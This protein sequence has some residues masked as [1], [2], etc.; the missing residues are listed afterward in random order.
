[1][2]LLASRRSQALCRRCQRLCHSCRDI[3]LA[4]LH[5]FAIGSNFASAMN[6]VGR[7]PR[8]TLRSLTAASRR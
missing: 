8:I 1:M 3:R 5:T 7:A 2:H 4:A 6:Y